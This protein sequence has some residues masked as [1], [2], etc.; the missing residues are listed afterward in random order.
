MIRRWASVAAAVLWVATGCEVE[1]VVPIENGTDASTGT[2]TDPDTGRTAASD[3][4]P[5]ATSDTSQPCEDPM[6]I[7]DGACVDPDTNPQHCGECG[8]DCDAG[9]SCVAGD[10]IDACGDSCNRDTEV[11][12]GGTCMCRIGFTACGTACVDLQT[13]ASFCGACDED[14]LDEPGEEYVCEAGECY[15]DT[16]CSVGLTQC[17]H[18]C[19]DLQSHPLHCDECDRP[20]DGDEVCIDGDCEDL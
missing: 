13:N 10:C 6:L 15:D 1:Y 20:C 3:T 16:G 11:C 18:S 2:G 7:C 14:C 8:E 9:G 4:D 17:G 5:A 19:V 12:A